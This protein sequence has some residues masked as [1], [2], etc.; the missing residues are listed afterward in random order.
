MK[1]FSL[2][3]VEDY[4]IKTDDDELMKTMVDE[5]TTSFDELLESFTLKLEACLPRPSRPDYENY[6]KICSL[7]GVA[8]ILLFFEPINMRLRNIIMSFH[9]PE[10][11]TERVMWLYNHILAKR[12]SFFKFTFQLAKRKLFKG[13]STKNDEMTCKDIFKAKVDR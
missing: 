8:W 6:A 13:K 7:I 4:V 10:R 11:N 3:L 1:T 12:S 5:F 9:F 2:D